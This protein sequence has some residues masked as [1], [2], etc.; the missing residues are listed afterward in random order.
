MDDFYYEESNTKHV[1]LKCLII[2]FIIGFC[3]GFFLYHKNSNT[4][5]L[6]NITIELGDELSKDVSDYLLTGVKNSNRYKLILNDVDVNSIGTYN[7]KVK[8][9][10]SSKTG[11][12]T[13]KD[14]KKPVVTTDNITIGVNEDF[15]LSILVN[16]CEDYSLPCSVNLKDQ[17]D[18]EKLKT[19]GEYNIKLIISDAA[20]NS[21]ESESKI[22][23]SE[24]ASLVSEKTKDLTYYTNSDNDNKLGHTLFVKFDKALYED[25]EDFESIYTDLTLEDFSKYTDKSIRTTKLINAYNK[26]GYVIGI[27]VLVTYEDGTTELLERNVVDNEEE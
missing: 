3:I 1:L 2:L 11:K 10:K 18:M 13:I 26:Y 4:I 6:K 8:Y 27:Q 9:N 5:K 16:K 17:N 25:T 7:Y 19:P 22:T 20:G 15:D 21:V 12:I 23:V 24:N 14:T